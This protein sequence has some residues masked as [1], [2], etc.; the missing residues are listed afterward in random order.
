MN[1]KFVKV[2]IPCLASLACLVGCGEDPIGPSKTGY[3]KDLDFTLEG[4]ELEYALQEHSFKKHVNYIP[5]SQF[6]SYC[7]NT[8]DHYSIERVS[9]KNT[10][11]QQFYTAKEVTGSTGTREHVWPCANSDNLWVHDK[12]NPKNPHNVDGTGYAGGGSDLYH[13]RLADST[14]NTAR[15]NSK[16][17]DFDD[18]AE[19]QKADLIEVGS[20]GGKYKIQITGYTKNEKTGKI[21]YANRVEV[22]DKMKGDVARTLLYVWM[23][24]SNRPSVPDGSTIV[25]YSSSKTKEIQYSDMV[26]KLNFRNIF[27]CRKP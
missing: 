12:D 2:L 10:K 15:G 3:Y 6:T 19:D 1:L 18:I 16:F 21:E 17:V 5:Y 26:G 25:K 23:H 11:N 22:D 7:S 20:S 8:K 14:V 13:V 24:Y 9:E 27:R 4:T